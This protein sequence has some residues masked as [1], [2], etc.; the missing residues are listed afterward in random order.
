[1]KTSDLMLCTMFFILVSLWGI[2]DH[3]TAANLSAEDK[4]LI[5]QQEKLEHQSKALMEKYESES[6]ERLKS[7]TWSESRNSNELMHKAIA[8]NL[9]HYLFGLVGFIMIL[10]GPALMRRHHEHS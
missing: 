9:H 3:L 5:I 7:M 4:A 10:S 6:Q 2:E 8:Q 1:M